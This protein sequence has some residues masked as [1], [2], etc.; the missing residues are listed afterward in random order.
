MKNILLLLAAALIVPSTIGQNIYTDVIGSAGD[1][2][3]ISNIVVSWTIGECMVEHYCNNECRFSQGFH[4]SY[5]QVLKVPE[6]TPSLL[7]VRVYPNPTPDILNIDLSS[8]T[9]GKTYQLMILDIKGTKLI[10]MEASSE[11][12][13]Q[14]SLSLFPNGMMFLHIIDQSKSAKSIFKIIKV[15]I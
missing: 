4:Q 1:E 14:L 11:D 13:V 15:R 9:P 7:E 2:D 3:T 6:E 8:L 10:E 12:L 5:Y